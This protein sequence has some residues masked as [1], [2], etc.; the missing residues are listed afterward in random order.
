MSLDFDPADLPPASRLYVEIAPQQNFGIEPESYL[1]SDWQSGQITLE[2]KGIRSE[3][4]V[5]LKFLDA[6]GQTL[7][8]SNAKHFQH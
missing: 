7:A 3:A 1:V 2:L 6:R 4:Y 8:I 5:R